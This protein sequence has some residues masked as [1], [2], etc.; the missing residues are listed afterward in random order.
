MLSCV[1]FSG[2]IKDDV[3]GV[4]RTEK[5]AGDRLSQCPTILSTLWSN[6]WPITEQTH[7]DV[8]CILSGLYILE[9]KIGCHNN[10]NLE[11]TEK[12]AYIALV[13][14]QLQVLAPGSRNIASTLI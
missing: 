3:T 6:V 1:P 2:R 8:T 12:M 4:V 14:V 10:I 9:T 11:T 5:V 7:S 13:T